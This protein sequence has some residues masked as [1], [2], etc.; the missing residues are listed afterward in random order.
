MGTVLLSVA[1]RA[2]QKGECLENPSALKAEAVLTSCQIPETLRTSSAVGHAPLVFVSKNLW[3]S[4]VSFL[5]ERK[6]VKI[7]QT[8]DLEQIELSEQL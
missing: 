3:T 4:L 8:G 6:D 1:A 5:G 2:E 7:F